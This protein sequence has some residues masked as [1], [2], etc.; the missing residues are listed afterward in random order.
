MGFI[1]KLT[2]TIPTWCQETKTLL[3]MISVKNHL[4]SENSDNGSVHKT[5]WLEP[6]HSSNSLKIA[7]QDLPLLPTQAC[8]VTAFVLQMT[9]AS[10]TLSRF[11]EV[12]YYG[13]I[14]S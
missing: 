7:T 11:G 5:V 1:L 2:F 8:A 4:T 10:I 14:T 13:K 12:L 6:Y 3:Q 9:P